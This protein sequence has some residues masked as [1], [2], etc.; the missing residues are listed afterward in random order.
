[1]EHP[2]GV[3][4][5][6]V[7]TAVPLSAATIAS[8]QSSQARHN[9]GISS[10]ELA[11]HSLLFDMVLIDTGADCSCINKQI[12]DKYNLQVNPPASGSP[13]SLV[14][15]DGVHTP[16]VGTVTLRVTVHCLLESEPTT[17]F[18]KSFEV[19]NGNHDFILG[20]DVLPTLFPNDTTYSYVAPAAPHMDK[21]HNI[22][23]GSPCPDSSQ[24]QILCF[25]SSLDDIDEEV[26][27][28]IIQH[29]FHYALAH[30][31]M[32]CADPLSTSSSSS[33]SSTAPVVA[34]TSAK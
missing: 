17:E 18:T 19:I 21:P 34:T 23:R 15:F 12:V 32:V 2:P 28:D 27:D 16:R 22:T 24:S 11:R 14:G 6:S 31:D 7:P 9:I 26:P 25:E 30:N 5:L 10:W 3:Y 33:S 1:M 13:S 4:S 20:R 29:S 8:A